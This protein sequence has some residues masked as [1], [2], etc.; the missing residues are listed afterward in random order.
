MYTRFETWNQDATCSLR[1]AESSGALILI[2]NFQNL[3][4]YEKLWNLIFYILT[5]LDFIFLSFLFLNNEI[6]A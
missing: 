5:I 2:S 4:T 1:M 6:F 3:G